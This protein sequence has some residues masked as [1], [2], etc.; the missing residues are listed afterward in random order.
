M[1]QRTLTWEPAINDPSDVSELFTLWLIGANKWRGQPW[2]WVLQRAVLECHLAGRWVGRPNTDRTNV[3]VRLLQRAMWAL[4]FNRCLMTVTTE[5]KILP[6]LHWSRRCSDN[7]PVPWNS[8]SEYFY[9]LEFLD[10]IPES[11]EHLNSIT[12]KIQ[13]PSIHVQVKT[14]EQ[15]RV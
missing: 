15:L 9:S 6:P 4:P 7:I 2:P 12:F 1:G 14:W 5:D 13:A 11:L 10:H 8:F 3:P